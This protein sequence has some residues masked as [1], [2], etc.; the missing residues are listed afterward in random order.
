MY[1]VVMVGSMA[2]DSFA[3]KYDTLEEATKWLAKRKEMYGSL[4]KI[5]LTKEV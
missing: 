5:Y 3:Y 1:F 2:G 4:Y